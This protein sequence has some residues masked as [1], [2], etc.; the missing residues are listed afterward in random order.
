VDA[1]RDL[2]ALEATELRLEA[3]SR[4]RREELE[5]R[6]RRRRI[7]LWLLGPLVLPAL[8]AAALLA[9]LER[10][11]GDLGGLPTPQAA[12]VLAGAFLLPAAVTAWLARRR[13]ALE[14]L[15]W[16]VASACVALVLVFGVGLLALGLGPE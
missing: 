6:A 14:A 15:A 5:R 16:A 1:E 7:R 12:L 10:E 8:G 4:Q 3:R 13:G 2:D 11:G 9:L